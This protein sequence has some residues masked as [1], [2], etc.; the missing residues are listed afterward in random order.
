MNKIDKMKSFNKEQ[1]MHWLCLINKDERSTQFCLTLKV[2]FQIQTLGVG[3]GN[4]IRKK[5]LNKD[6]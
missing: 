3:G 1:K 6:D 2:C 4:V 5:Y